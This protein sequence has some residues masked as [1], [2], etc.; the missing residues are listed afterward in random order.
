M[1]MYV[2]K[3]LHFVIPGKRIKHQILDYILSKTKTKAANTTE[4]NVS[5]FDLSRDL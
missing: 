1:T 4:I 5:G 3:V 2:L